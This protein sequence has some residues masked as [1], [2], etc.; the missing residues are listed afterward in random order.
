MAYL[1]NPAVA[2]PPEPLPAGIWLLVLGL[3][4][5]LCL[6]MGAVGRYPFALAAGLGINAAVAFQLAPQIG[7]AGAMGTDP[8]SAFSS[9]STTGGDSFSE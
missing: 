5:I 1:K 2:V 6:A 9:F 7:F 8:L 3:A 4:G